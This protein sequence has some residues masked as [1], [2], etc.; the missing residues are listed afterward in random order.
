MSI[1][2][3]ASAERGVIVTEKK[4]NAPRTTTRSVGIVYSIKP[5]VIVGELADPLNRE[6]AN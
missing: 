6:R 2:A 4:G 1:D 3:Y 5:I